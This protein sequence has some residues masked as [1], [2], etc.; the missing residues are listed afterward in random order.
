MVH[1]DRALLGLFEK[2]P[3][4]SKFQEQI[5]AR[6]SGDPHWNEKPSAKTL[7][8]D[9]TLD[10]LKRALPLGRP[11]ARSNPNPWV[12]PRVNPLESSSTTLADTGGMMGGLLGGSALLLAY[13]A[14]ASAAAYAWNKIRG[15]DRMD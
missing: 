13:G 1:L 6:H 11:G 4:M 15:R 10:M 9:R 7:E 14:A 12:T 8:N 3:D 2:S 5:E